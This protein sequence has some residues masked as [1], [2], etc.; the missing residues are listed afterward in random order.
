MNITNGAF[1]NIP[2]SIFEGKTVII[3]PLTTVVRSPM[4]FNE[5]DVWRFQTTAFITEA[6]HLVRLL[7]TNLIVHHNDL[8]RN[9]NHLRQL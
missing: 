2:L 7:E 4:R 1:S 8:D 6:E 3:I 5:G 9:E